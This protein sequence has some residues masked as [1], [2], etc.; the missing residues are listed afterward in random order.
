MRRLAV[1]DDEVLAVHDVEGRGVGTAFFERDLETA[2]H[3]AVD[4]DKGPGEKEPALLIGAPFRG[5]GGELV[6]RVDLGVD[7]ERHEPNGQS[8][9]PSAR[10][11]SSTCFCRARILEVSIGH[12]AWQAVKM[13]SA[14]QMVPSRSCELERL[15]ALVVERKRFH[16]A[17]H[18]RR[19]GRARGMTTPRDDRQR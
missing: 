17:E 13:K 3:C 1:D 9:C 10:S 6:R 4:L 8:L 15:A 18:G 16:A 2:R 14:T 19:L 12:A 5:V 7:G 11:R